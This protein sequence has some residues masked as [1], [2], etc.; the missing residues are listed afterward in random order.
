MRSSATTGTAIDANCP[1]DISPSPI[2]RSQLQGIVMH[3]FRFHFL[4]VVGLCAA[5]T[6]VALAGSFRVF[7]F[8]D[9]GAMTLKAALEMLRTA[10]HRSSRA[11]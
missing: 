11:I 10:V 8:P 3:L 4:L 1:F 6:A 7:E 2:L 5:L 9:H